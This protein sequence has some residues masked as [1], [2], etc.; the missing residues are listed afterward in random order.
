VIFTSH[1]EGLL[2]AAARVMTLRDGRLEE[3][4]ERRR[5][6][7]APRAPRALPQPAR[8]LTAPEAA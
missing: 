6:L 1:R 2:R 5:L 3:T 8:R 7:A 4:G